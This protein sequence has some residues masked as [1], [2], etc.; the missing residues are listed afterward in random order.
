MQLNKATAGTW[1]QTALPTA[2]PRLPSIGW[3]RERLGKCLEPAPAPL[4]NPANMWG[5]PLKTPES[6]P[7]SALKNR[8]TGPNNQNCAEAGPLQITNNLSERHLSLATEVLE[9]L[10]EL[11]PWWNH[12]VFNKVERE[13]VPC[14]PAGPETIRFVRSGALTRSKAQIPD[15]STEWKD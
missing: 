12:P 9:C 15:T 13:D 11:R 5:N 14:D 7:E 6:C 1:A 2:G 3:V 10:G 4:E 8:S